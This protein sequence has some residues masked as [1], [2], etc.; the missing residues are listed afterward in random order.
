VGRTC[1]E[2]YEEHSVR[3]NTSRR[4]SGVNRVSK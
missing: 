3:H 2:K 1:R 4:G